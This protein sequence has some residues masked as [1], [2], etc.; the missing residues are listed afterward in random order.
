[1]GQTTAPEIYFYRF[2]AN[3][4]FGL[5]INGVDKMTGRVSINVARKVMEE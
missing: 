4:P 5:Q 3:S 2:I 1:M